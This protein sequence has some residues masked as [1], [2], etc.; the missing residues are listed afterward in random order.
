MITEHIRAY[1]SIQVLRYDADQT[2]WAM[3]K[4]QRDFGPGR[5]SDQGIRSW[6]GQPLSQEVFASYGIAPYLVTRDDD[7][8]LVTL[9]GWGAMLGG[10]AGTT[11]A[12]KYSA[13]SARIGIGTSSAQPVGG[14]TFLTSDTGS[15]S[16]T[17]YFQLVSAAPAIAAGASPA[18]LTF[19]ASFGGTVANFP[20]NEFGTDNGAASGVTG[21][22]LGL[23]L[24]NAGQSPQGTKPT[25]ETWIIVETLNFGY[26]ANPGVLS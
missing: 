1:T 18:T 10:I 20:W 24:L 8:N 23:T 22:G 15:G 13:T 17:S 2:S 3:R 9:G 11:I 19:T 16:V 14:M 6:P 7:C 4:S 26:P 21:Q 12:S 5:G 25:G